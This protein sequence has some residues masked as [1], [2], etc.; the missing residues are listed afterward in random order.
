MEP[1]LLWCGY[2]PILSDP[3]EE[4]IVGPTTRKFLFM[5]PDRNPPKING[6]YKGLASKFVESCFKIQAVADKG[7]S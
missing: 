3:S 4:N 1:Q 5:G 6:N 2:H 7:E